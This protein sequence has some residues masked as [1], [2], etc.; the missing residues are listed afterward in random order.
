MQPMSLSCLIIVASIPIFHVSQLK[1]AKGEYDM[2][3]LPNQITESLELVAQPE[4]LLDWRYNQPVP[5][6]S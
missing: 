2:V 5:W 6:R 4:T 1:L 3:E